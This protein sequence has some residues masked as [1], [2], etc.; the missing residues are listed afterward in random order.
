MDRIKLVVLGDS[1]VGKSSL[2]TR[3]IHM[4]YDDYHPSTIGAAFMSKRIITPDGKSHMLEIWDTA[5]QEK[6]RSIASMY[7]NRSSIAIVCYDITEIDSY[8]AAK[9]W[10]NELCSKT[11][12]YEKGIV[13]LCGTKSDLEQDRVIPEEDVK[14]YA[15]ENG[16]QFI[17]TSSKTGDN[18]NELF[19][20]IGSLIP[21]M[22]QTIL[23]DSKKKS[24]QLEKE[25][26]N[27]ESEWGCC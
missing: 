16:F 10:V 17:E 4:R 18:V 7:Y 24:F 26:Q 23:D 13:V 12:I 5:G 11:D 20:M 9:S 25:L 27:K 19:E 22:M 8:L 21:D 15:Y 1:S 2:L 6:Y 14:Q 3:Y